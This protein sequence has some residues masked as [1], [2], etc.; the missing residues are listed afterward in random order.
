[1]ATLVL[2]DRIQETGTVSTGTGSVNLAGAVNGFKSFIN[3]IGNGNITYY[4]I[5]DPITYAWEVG[6]GTVTSGTPNTLSR[7]TK[8]TVPDHLRI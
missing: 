5:Y 3:G 8:E 6:V 2:A 4:A 7:T 1:M